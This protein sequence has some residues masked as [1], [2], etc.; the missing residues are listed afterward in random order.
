MLVSRYGELSMKKKKGRVAPLQRMFFV[1]SVLLA[2][3]FA[4]FGGKVQAAVA[5]H[6]ITDTVDPDGITIN[7]FD[8]WLTAQNENGQ[9]G[10][11]DSDIGINQNHSLKFGA[12]QGAGIN[13]WGSGEIHQGIVSGL[14]GEDGYPI[15][16]GDQGESLA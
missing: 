10:S 12:T 3:V 9:T 4:P 14:L 11:R 2:A 7:L 13:A 5:D 8:Y 1:L 6:I 16:A 15:L